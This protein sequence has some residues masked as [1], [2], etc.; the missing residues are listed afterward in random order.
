MEY[1]TTFPAL[2]TTLYVIW[3]DVYDTILKNQIVEWL[4]F[5]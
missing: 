2:Q 4:K 3:V 5:S 1:I